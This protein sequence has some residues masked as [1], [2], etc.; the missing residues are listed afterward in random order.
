M[1]T[2]DEASQRWLEQFNR[3]VLVVT[4]VVCL[5]LLGGAIWLGYR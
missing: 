3:G 4:V 2:D 1:V 5:V